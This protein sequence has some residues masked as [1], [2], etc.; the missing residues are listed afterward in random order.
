MNW[1][2]LLWLSGILLLGILVD[3]ILWRL[4]RNSQIEY[5]NPGAKILGYRSPI[6]SWLRYKWAQAEL[7]LRQTITKEWLL[8]LLEIVLITAWALWITKPYADFNREVWP[9]GPD[10]SRNIQLFSTWQN[11]PICG[12][13]VFWNGTI[14]G[15]APAFADM[16]TPVLNPFFIISTMLW[17]VISGAK[18]LL[19]LSFI[20][21]GLAQL[22]L[23]RVL[24]LSRLAR[25]WTAAI[26]VAGGHLST[27]LEMGH[28]VMVIP[29]AAGSL[30]LAAALDVA[31]TGRRRSV[32]ILALTMA[33][34]IVSG[35]GYIQIAVLLGFIPV[36]LLYCFDNQL[37][38]RPVWRSFIWSAILT[39]LLTAVFWLPMIHFWPHV[40]K[41]G[42]PDFLGGQPME[43][44]LLNLVIPDRTFLYTEILEKSPAPAMF[45]MYIGWVPI[46]LVF[47]AF[48]FTPRRETR[49][50]MALLLAIFLIFFLNS[51]Q[52]FRWTSD[53]FGSFFGAARNLAL[54][55]PITIPMILALAGWG[56]DGLIR[57]PWPRLSINNQS[58]GLSLVILLVIPLVWG[59]NSVRVYSADWIL[60]E[61]APDTDHPMKALTTP[62]ARWVAMPFDD[63]AAFPKAIEAGLKMIIFHDFTA[64][65]WNDRAV[66]APQV[67]LTRDPAFRDNPFYTH[68]LGPWVVLEH[69]ELPYAYVKTDVGTVVPCNA[70]A[71]GGHI[72]VACNTVHAGTLYVN[73]N[74]F[75]GWQASVNGQAVA[76]KGDMI[77]FPVPSG[78][79]AIQLR[80]RPWDVMVGGMLTILGLILC[81]YLWWRP[82]NSLPEEAP[83]EE[84]EN[85]STI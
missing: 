17:G 84:L 20:L 38:F 9:R 27:R 35:H 60:T 58:I 14:N 18:V 29:I 55:E 74:Y 30:M 37:R 32:V 73:E 3:I 26:A 76:V 43:Y 63:F 23:G 39:I 78:T 79:S 48:R 12:D 24:G 46:I 41:D 85:S 16:F 33:L 44:A 10:F 15:G 40:Q 72:D 67:E 52:L 22:W 7:S 53:S 49:T 65:N 1:Q 62:Y 28:I 66:P 42:N 45:G 13:C 80:Y 51:G 6:I 83:L 25:L 19:I 61:P 57:L 31:R 5:L 71:I 82:I 2:S 75:S 77:N 11:L 69:P 68:D 36:L 59:L 8:S 34:T 4:L 70:T 56:L 21:A 50:F 81:G 54:L 47:F 64:W